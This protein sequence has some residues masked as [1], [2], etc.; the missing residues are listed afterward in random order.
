MLTT[1]LL[2][3]YLQFTL[4]S[5]HSLWGFTA[6]KE[7]N[8]RAVFT[9]PAPMNRFYKIHLYY[10][11]EHAVDAD[12]RVHVNEKEGPRHFIDL[13][14]FPGYPDYRPPKDFK[15]ALDSFGMDSLRHFGLLPWQIEKTYSSLISAMARLD[16][17]SI[18]RHSADLGHYLADAHVPLHTTAN[19]NGQLSGQAGI[20]AFWE[21]R[22][23][24]LFMQEY[25]LVTGAA[26]Y[27]YSVRDE[28]WRI[29]EHSHQLVDSVLT[30][31][32]DLR[33]AYPA[34]R[35]HGFH[36]R[37]GQLLFQYSAA[38]SKSYNQVLNGMVEKQ[39][40]ASIHALGSFWYSAW[41]DAGQPDLNKISKK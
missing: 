31:E 28:I 24:E 17:K 4:P 39:F 9:L 6:H 23:P 26:Y 30:L 35:V 5:K 2:G 22:L 40:R 27:I 20:H 1:F 16:K 7:I 3:F 8:R 13:D 29:V 32:S 10:L 25:E 33:K 15:T 14:D 37:K 12:K 19:Y 36:S 34:D 41:V 18:L 11:Q 21:T 38:Y